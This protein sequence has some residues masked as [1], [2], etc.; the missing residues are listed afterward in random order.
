MIV[1]AKQ[2]KDSA[3]EFNNTLYYFD[4]STESI[5]YAISKSA[6]AGISNLEFR[7]ELSNDQKELLKSLGYEVTEN[8]NNLNYE[9]LY[10]EVNWL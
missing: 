5:F 4:G 2:A 1:T 9:V 6:E 3:I 10:T 7:G 8:A